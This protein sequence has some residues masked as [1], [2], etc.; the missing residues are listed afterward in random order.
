MLEELEPTRGEE[1]VKVTAM[2][3]GSTGLPFVSLATGA[4]QEEA[5]KRQWERLRQFL[6]GL[7]ERVKELSERMDRNGEVRDMLPDMLPEIVA[8]VVRERS[9]K[10]RDCYRRIMLNAILAE[11]SDYDVILDYVRTLERFTENHVRML[12]VMHDPVGTDERQGGEGTKMESSRYAFV[13][14]L[15]PNWEEQDIKRIWTDLY[16]WQIITA[17]SYGGITT[18][19]PMMYWFD[20]IFSDYGRGL[21]HYLLDE[22]DGQ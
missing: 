17:E 19:H 12:A 7:D 5:A 2:L 18:P 21:V 4:L 10:K 13:Q 3:L 6:E 22:V 8:R 16:R 20:G 9:S 15:F 11:T 14:I 1:W